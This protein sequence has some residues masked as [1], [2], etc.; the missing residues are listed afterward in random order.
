[1]CAFSIF[2]PFF[3][4]LLAALVVIQIIVNLPALLA[5]LP[6]ASDLQFLGYL[7]WH[8]R[9][10]ADGPPF[11]QIAGKD[12]ERRVRHETIREPATTPTPRSDVECERVRTEPDNLE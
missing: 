12:G 9:P 3:F 2:F 7:L 8:G 11:G 10:R 6:Q 1:M 5:P 4:G